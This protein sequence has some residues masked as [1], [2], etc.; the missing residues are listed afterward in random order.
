[1]VK[2]Y[3]LVLFLS[4]LAGFATIIGALIAPCCRKNHKALV[5]GLGFASGI[6]ILISFFELIPES[7]A[8]LRIYKTLIFLFV[9]VL[10]MSFL[11]FLIPH[12]H[13][14]KEERHSM[15][16]LKTAYLTAFGIILH[17][18][19]EGFAIASSYIY[20][21]SLGLLVFLA[22]LVH[23][24]PEGFAMAVPAVPLKKKNF[25]LKIALTSGISGLL[26]SVIGIFSLSIMPQL[27]SF[28]LA[29]AAGAMVYVS[30]HELLP[31]ARKYKENFFLFL[32]AILSFIFYFG[33]FFIFPD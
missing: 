11:N 23:N 26:G 5:L 20:S 7:I 32:G 13:L 28:F 9:S 33:L 25:V 10:I 21:S 1:M 3:Y 2:N 18:F 17:D 16:S 12:I 30:I 4:F 24:I 6:M 19:P 14:I 22:T 27:E 8:E 31:M 29:M 15:S